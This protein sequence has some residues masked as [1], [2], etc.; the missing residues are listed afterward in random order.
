M[1]LS[2]SA[3]DIDEA[4]A[5]EIEVLWYPIKA[6]KRLR[7]IGYLT[8]LCDNRN[9]SGKDFRKCCKEVADEGMKA[10]EAHTP[11]IATL[12]RKLTGSFEIASKNSFWR[13]IPDC[14]YCIGGY[15]YVAY[16]END[17]FSRGELF[18]CCCPKAKTHPAKD[19]VN[20]PRWDDIEQ[21]RRQG[22]HLRII[23]VEDKDFPGEVMQVLKKEKARQFLR[24]AEPSLKKAVDSIP[25]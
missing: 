6:D 21:Q 12:V 14:R 9:I 23:E 2:A 3:I 19:I 11:Q 7:A 13:Q 4:L 5:E 24:L 20:M 25:F 8:D 22:T 1:K 10:K 18:W 17:L 16:Y 15:A